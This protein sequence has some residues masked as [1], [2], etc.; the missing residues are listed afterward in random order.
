MPFSQC[1]VS[2]LETAPRKCL[3]R[4][5]EISETL[6]PFSQYAIS[7]L[8]TAP[9]EVFTLF[10]QGCFFP[11]IAKILI[12]STYYPPKNLERTFFGPVLPRAVP[13]RGVGNHV[14]NLRNMPWAMGV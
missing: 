3:G 11:K 9:L 14:G 10:Q 2:T 7:D 12:I 1:F 13:S 5:F 4:C 8:E 6:L